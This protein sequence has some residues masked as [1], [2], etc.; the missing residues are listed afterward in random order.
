MNGKQ[1][2]FLIREL[3]LF[4]CCFILLLWL[5][6]CEVDFLDNLTYACVDLLVTLN[7]LCRVDE[8]YIC[9]A[10][11]C[12]VML[13]LAP[14]FSDSTFE[15]IAF[16]SSFEQFFRYRHHDSVCIR[17][18]IGHIQKSQPGNIPVL[19]FGKELSNGGL[20]TE[21]FLFRKGVRCL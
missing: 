3:T 5:C 7:L 2:T 11:C 16:Y 10:C 21:S 6:I 17:P 19:P 15:Q 18:G 13:L 8:E 12:Q 14:A 20:A 4:C 9:S 1:I